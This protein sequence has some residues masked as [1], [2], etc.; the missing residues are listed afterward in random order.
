MVLL[1]VVFVGAD[2]I[3]SVGLGDEIL[4]DLIFA[5]VL[6]NLNLKAVAA[7]NGIAE[8]VDILDLGDVDDIG[9]V[10]L[11]FGRC[12]QL[13]LGEEDILSVCEIVLVRGHGL[14]V[15]A[16]REHV[17][18][19][20]LVRFAVDGNRG[21][22]AVIVNSKGINRAFDHAGQRDIK[23]LSAAGKVGG[24][25]NDIVLL[26]SIQEVVL[27]KVICITRNADIVASR[28]GGAENVAV[29][30]DLHDLS[31]VGLGHKSGVKQAV[32]SGVDQLDL[33]SRA[34][35]TQLRNLERGGGSKVD[36]RG[37]LDVFIFV[38]VLFTVNGNNVLFI[39]GFAR[40][41]IQ[42]YFHRGGLNSGNAINLNAIVIAGGRLTLGN[43]GNLLTQQAV[44]NIIIQQ[45]GLVIDFDLAV[46]VVAIFIISRG[47]GK[48]NVAGGHDDTL[49]GHHFQVRLAKGG[50][51]ADDFAH[52]I[53][54]LFNNIDGVGEQLCSPLARSRGIE[55]NIVRV[56][57]AGI[58]A[59][60]N[61]GLLPV[62]AGIVGAVASQD[63]QHFGQFSAGHLT[64]GIK[65]AVADAVNNTDAG[66]VCNITLGP[67]PFGV[68]E[69]AC[70]GPAS[71]AV[72]VALHFE[73]IDH[74][75]G[76]STRDGL[77]GIKVSLCVA[78][79]HVQG[80]QKFNISDQIAVDVRLILK[81]GSGGQ[82][83]HGSQHH[84]RC[85]QFFQRSH[86]VPPCVFLFFSDHCPFSENAVKRRRYKGLKRE[87]VNIMTKMSL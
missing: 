61:D 58:N 84:G 27:C 20:K 8:G 7:H 15:L 38:N 77:F 12:G 70:S 36:I 65:L 32:I 46:A 75:S 56:K 34:K 1:A 16:A 52:D 50:A 29:S 6:Q 23:A 28:I 44:R 4:E 41:F 17:G 78:L 66:A 45:I 31:K 54:G 39:R 64:F 69:S 87:R 13:A 21:N 49:I 14:G 57:H 19:G 51:V 59:I 55:R 68:G 9:H 82:R 83:E 67:V 3:V 24:D 76:L 71:G 35:V 74:F 79:D 81:S 60:S 47:I 48:S 80:S 85:Q 33:V 30:V 2:R 72:V 62:V 18:A 40:D 5:V 10:A 11:V 22:V 37:E 63:K 86:V 43:K 53:N 26:D 73:H 25:G 42:S